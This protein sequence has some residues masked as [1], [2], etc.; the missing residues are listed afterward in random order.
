M[1]F[2]DIPT[3][4]RRCVRHL[5]DGLGGRG[6]LVAGTGGAMSQSDLEAALAF[7]MKVAGLPEPVRELRFAPPRRYRFDFAFP[8]AMLA[9]ECEGGVHSGGRHV[10]GKGYE[11][12]CEKGNLATLLGWRVLRFTAATITDGR[13]LAM[14]EQA[15]A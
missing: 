14:I 2:N 6:V 15:M 7:Q 1:R 10:R 11:S 8:D 4:I 12:D 5:S 9:I 3:R 13:A